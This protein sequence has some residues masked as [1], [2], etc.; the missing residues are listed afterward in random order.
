MSD[1]VNVVITIPHG[2][3]FTYRIPH[4]FIHRVKPGMQVIVPFGQKE[5]SG[6]V[7]EVNDSPPAE[8][9]AENIKEISDVLFA[10]P[11][12]PPDLL[13]LLSW[14]SRYYLCHLGEAFRLIQST[15]FVK[16]ARL[17]VKRTS[18][19][20]P[21]NLTPLQQKILALLPPEK[22]INVQWLQKEAGSSDVRSTLIQLEQK[23]LIARRY[24]S[25]EKS[26]VKKQEDY[27]R[28]I[29]EDSLLPQALEKI[30]DLQRGKAVRVQQ[31]LAALVPD[32][33]Q[34]WE[35]LK[36]QK[37]SKTVLDRLVGQMIVE[38]E[39]REVDRSFENAFLEEFGSITLNDEQKKFVENASRYI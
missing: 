20:L 16:S 4:E 9:P 15:L 30:K 35:S 24:S 26:P 37:V 38:K 12:L 22:E 21:H 31:A 13:K 8:I 28:L 7:L 27:Y 1:Y 6:I 11:A 34:S 29:P 19:V 18:M 5:V 2:D 14:I 33:W 32:D 25:V 39:S 3:G 10:Q 23:D 36:L 17:L